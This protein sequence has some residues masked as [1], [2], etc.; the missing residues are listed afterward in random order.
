MAVGLFVIG[1]ADVGWGERSS[2]QRTS[3]LEAPWASATDGRT[4]AMDP[5][6]SSSRSP[7]VAGATPLGSTH[8]DIASME[9]EAVEAEL[10]A[11]TAPQHG[12]AEG[13]ASPEGWVGLIP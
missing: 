7:H 10:G 1:M 3:A 8:N 6:L 9:A 2:P 13:M 4:P 11:W 12:K 5:A